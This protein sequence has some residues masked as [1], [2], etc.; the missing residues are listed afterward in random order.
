MVVQKSES[1]FPIQ[2]LLLNS[3]VT[4]ARWGLVSFCCWNEESFLA[5]ESAKLFR[6]S[7]DR[8]SSPLNSKVGYENQRPAHLLLRTLAL[9]TS[10]WDSKR[11]RMSWRI[12]SGNAEMRSR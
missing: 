4:A 3:I 1:W 7:L 12:S 9:P 10:F 11:D 5:A 6:D 8:K 2:P